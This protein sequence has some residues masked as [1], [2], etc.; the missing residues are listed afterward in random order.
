ML[1]AGCSWIGR[2]LYARS[3]CKQVKQT[4]TK[5]NYTVSLPGASLCRGPKRRENEQ[6]ILDY[7]A[8]DGQDLDTDGIICH[9]KPFL[10]HIFRWSISQQS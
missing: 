5:L 8:P 2:D 10:D 6:A 9:T 4:N 3:N 1:K 7:G